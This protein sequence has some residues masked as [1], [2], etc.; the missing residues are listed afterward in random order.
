VSIEIVQ[1]DIS[2]ES[3]QCLNQLLHDD[4][5]FILNAGQTEQGDVN[6]G[7]NTNSTEGLEPTRT[8]VEFEMDDEQESDSQES[9]SD[10]LENTTAF[11]DAVKNAPIVKNFHGGFE[12]GICRAGGGEREKG[13]D[14]RE[15]RKLIDMFAMTRSQLLVE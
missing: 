6:H 2:V 9:H 15:E 11:E 7:P 8:D 12:Y 1:N 13:S 3:A 14:S 4:Q 10:I 5:A